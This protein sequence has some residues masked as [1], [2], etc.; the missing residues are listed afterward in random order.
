M[1][2][3]NKKDDIVLKKVSYIHNLIWFKKD[4]VKTLIDFNSKVNAI[5]LV[6]IAKLGS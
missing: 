5:T 4:K 6:Y 3:A 1:I 2:E